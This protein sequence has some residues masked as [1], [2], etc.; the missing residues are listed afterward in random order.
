MP[1]KKYKIKTMSR[2]E[3]DIA[4]DWARQEG[5]NPGLYDADAFYA[6]DPNPILWV[7][8]LLPQL[9]ARLI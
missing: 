2:K 9:V 7:I 6:Q 5:W 1:D 3:L 8:V 4:V